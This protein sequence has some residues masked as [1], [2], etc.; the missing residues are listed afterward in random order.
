MRETSPAARTPGEPVAMITYASFCSISLFKQNLSKTYPDQCADRNGPTSPSL[1]RRFR[2]A[3][4]YKQR[5]APIAEKQWHV[6]G[7][8]Q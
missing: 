8:V 7:I 1:F 6:V 4:G 5:F 2:E 3:F